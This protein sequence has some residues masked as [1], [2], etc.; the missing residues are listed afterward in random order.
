MT[1]PFVGQLTF[2]RVYSGVLHAGSSVYNATKGKTERIGRLLKMHA[3]KREEIKEVY[4]G[5]IAAAVG[6][7]SVTH[8]R[9]ALRREEADRA[10][11]D[12]LPRA[13]HLAGDRAED[14]GR[15]GEARRRACRS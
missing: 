14:Q 13:G 11:V 7:K 10:R 3:N 4:A 9:H 15:P 1:D 2:I 8:R 5:D 6:L 12:G